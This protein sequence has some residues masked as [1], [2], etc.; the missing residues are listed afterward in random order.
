ML[1][2]SDMGSMHGLQGVRRQGSVSAW[3]GQPNLLELYSL[4]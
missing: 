3:L 2:I 1:Q 4:S